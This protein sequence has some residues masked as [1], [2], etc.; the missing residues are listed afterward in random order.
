MVTSVAMG[1]IQDIL[2]DDDIAYHNTLMGRWH[3]NRKEYAEAVSLFEKAAEQG[4]AEAQYSLGKCYYNG[5]GVGKDFT[6]AVSWFAKAAEQGNASAQLM[7]GA[8]YSSG[9]GVS[10]DAAKSFYW[11]S[12]AAGQG[13]ASA[14]LMLGHRYYYGYG[15]GMDYAKAVYWYG[16]AAQQGNTEAQTNLGNC[17]SEGCGVSQDYARAV[18]WYEKAAA[19][20]DALAQSNLGCCYYNGEGVS[21]D[22]AKAVY[23]FSIAAAQGCPEAQYNLGMW[24]DKV[25]DKNNAAYWCEKAVQADFEYKNQAQLFLASIY[26][27]NPNIAGNYAKAVKYL[28][29]AKESNNNEI[30]GSACDLL[31]KCYR[32][33]RGVAQDIRK[34][35][36][37]LAEAKAKGCGGDVDV[38]IEKLKKEFSVAR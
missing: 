33:G 12:K 8:C 19:Q 37:L 10:Q 6:K 3:Y 18:Y 36:E 31:S 4:N 34:A 21:K 5:E 38:L 28:N 9:D 17:Y 24:Y 1:Q 11:Y 16:K 13:N 23:W 22:Y 25:E 26:Y 2:S 20:G 7:L 30:S 15:V 35:D 32:N 29:L 14:Q 27:K